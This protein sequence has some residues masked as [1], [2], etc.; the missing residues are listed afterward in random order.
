MAFQ[1]RE[2]AMLTDL[3][4]FAGL[5][6]LP[7]LVRAFKNRAKRMHIRRADGHSPDAQLNATE[8]QSTQESHAKVLDRK[9]KA[10]RVG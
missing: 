6:G 5:A 8:R 2:R 3:E 7:R 10:K 4:R 1:R 9:R